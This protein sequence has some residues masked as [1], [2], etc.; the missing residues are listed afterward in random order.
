MHSSRKDLFGYHNRWKV[1]PGHHPSQQ[2]VLRTAI[3][4][5][6]VCFAGCVKQ[7]GTTPARRVA[8]CQCRSP[9]DFYHNF[10]AL[11]VM[12]RPDT[13]LQSVS[14]YTKCPHINLISEQSS[15]DT[16]CNKLRVQR[17]TWL[18]TIALHPSYHLKKKKKKRPF[19]IPILT[20]SLFSIPVLKCCFCSDKGGQNLKAFQKRGKQSCSLQPICS[21]ACA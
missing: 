20:V 16:G 11:H 6:V 19:D 1:T 10:K 9:D 5:V 12:K 15:S 13:K 14:H 3:A 18:G 2:H 21:S 8:C 17:A 4:W 7:V